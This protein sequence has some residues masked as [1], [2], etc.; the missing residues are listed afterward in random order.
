MLTR[1][2]FKVLFSDTRVIDNKT[3]PSKLFSQAGHLR[4]LD[5]P[6][7]GRGLHP[8]G[9]VDSVAQEHEP[10]KAQIMKSHATAAA[11]QG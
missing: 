6:R 1:N 2:P 5:V 8:A 7:L 11:Q 4:A 9:D 10:G 3:S